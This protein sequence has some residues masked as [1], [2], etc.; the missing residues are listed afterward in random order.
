MDYQQMRRFSHD[1]SDPMFTDIFENVPTADD[2]GILTSFNTAVTAQTFTTFNGALASGGAIVFAIPRNV[3]IVLS[4]NANHDLGDAT[5][6]GTDINGAPQ[7][8]VISCR[9][10]GNATEV[11]V[12]AFRTITSY[13]HP[14]GAGTAG[15]V[16]VGTGT[17]L[18]LRKKPLVA[19]GAIVKGIEISAG[20][21][22]TNGTL[23]IPST[24]G[25]NGT[26]SP[27]T[28]P[29]NTNDYA[30]QYALDPAA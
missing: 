1:F 21:Y 6:V 20:T 10:D 19:A 5:I 23:V 22:V 27:N 13:T 8:E 7:T 29:N 12:K 26:Y 2:D 14:L 4:N 11:G 30:I 3:V 24:A 9:N 17:K 18:A 28:A 25:A 15:T 16:T